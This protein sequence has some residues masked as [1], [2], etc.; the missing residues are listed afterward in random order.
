MGGGE[1]TARHG[2]L[3]TLFHLDNLLH[4]CDSAGITLF[5]VKHSVWFIYRTSEGDQKEEHLLSINNPSELMEGRGWWW[6]WRKLKLWRHKQAKLRYMIQ[7]TCCSVQDLGFKEYTGVLVSDAGEEQPLC[8]HWTT[9]YNNLRS[10]KCTSLETHPVLTSRTRNLF[11][12]THFFFPMA[13]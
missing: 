5:A 2:R 13:L 8:L 6:W 7:L 9:W 1:G 11:I 12:S 10:T 4:T 3:F